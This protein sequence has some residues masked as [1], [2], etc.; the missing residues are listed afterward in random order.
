MTT[1]SPSTA[2]T[3]TAPTR[4]RRRRRSDEADHTGS[5]TGHRIF[6]L[7]LADKATVAAEIAAHSTRTLFFVRT[8]R[9]ADR[10]ARQLRHAGVP[11]G[12]LYSSLNRN[13]RRRAV[14]AFANGR[15]SSLVATELAAPGLRVDGLALVVH[16]DPVTDPKNYTHR[17]GRSVRAGAT[18]TVLSLVE[19]CQ[20]Y[21]LSV[22]H[23]AAGIRATTTGV[24]PGHPAIKHLTEHG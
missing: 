16:Y 19:A 1:A 18:G 8:E 3:R 7:A 22:I 23:A 6:R 9:G 20:H 4:P 24:I 5:A 11:A 2:P 10:L 15:S 17:C 14:D 12:A 21:D 13:Q